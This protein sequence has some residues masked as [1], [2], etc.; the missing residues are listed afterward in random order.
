MTQA[1]A[2]VKTQKLCHNCPAIY[3]FSWKGRETLI[4]Q[5]L[6]KTF[7]N[8]Q[9]HLPTNPLQCTSLDLRCGCDTLQNC[10]TLQNFM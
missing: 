8:T 7:K 3:L 1:W 5:T 2:W 9:V 6:L 10:P 4:P